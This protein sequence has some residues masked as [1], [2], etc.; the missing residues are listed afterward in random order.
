M[1]AK[2]WVARNLAATLLAGAWNAEA[3][4]QRTEEQLGTSTRRSQRALVRDLLER[5][6]TAYPP[7]TAWL[8]AF[9]LASPWFERASEPARRNP[10][11]FEAVAASPHF[12]L[13]PAFARLRVP[14]LETPVDLAQ[15]LDVSLDQLDWFADA[16]RQHRHAAIPALQHYTYAFLTKRSAALHR[17]TFM[18]SWSDARERLEN[19]I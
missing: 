7:S 17:I 5:V 6:P 19:C 3:L 15:W 9:L 11:P 16:K 10:A 13:A 1:N 12:N 2:D 14:R 8:V 18:G 4:L